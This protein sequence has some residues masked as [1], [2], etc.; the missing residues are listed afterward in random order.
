LPTFGRPTMATTGR[1]LAGMPRSVRGAGAWRGNAACAVDRWTYARPTVGGDERGGS[2]GDSIRRVVFQRSFE[3]RDCSHLGSVSVVS[4]ARTSCAR[5]VAEGTRTVH[6]RMCLTCGEVACCDSSPARHARH[7]HE[8]TGHP[9]IRSVEPGEEWLW[10]YL[11]RAY[12]S[13]PPVL[14]GGEPRPG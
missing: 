4:P 13:G 11:D 6:L 1:E 14:G 10:C 2:A 9:L 8:E 7:H 5:C 12:L 3:H